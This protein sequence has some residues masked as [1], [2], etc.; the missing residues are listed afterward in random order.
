M[1]VIKNVLEL[2]YSSLH[3]SV[4]KLNALNCTLLTGDLWHLNY[5]SKKVLKKTHTGRLL[6]KSEF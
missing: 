1:C 6:H 4:N 5:T 3:G 2:D